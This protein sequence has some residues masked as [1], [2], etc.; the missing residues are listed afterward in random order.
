VLAF[1]LGARLTVTATQYYKFIPTFIL[2]LTTLSL[3]LSF[4]T[5]TVSVLPAMVAPTDS[6]TTFEV[7]STMKQ[8]VKSE[9]YG[10]LTDPKNVERFVKDYFADMPI[11]AR[12]AACES[13]NR[14]FNSNG[15]VLRGEKTPLDR[16]VMQIN[17]YYHAAAAAK[18]GLDLHNIDDNVAYARF[19]YEKYGAK[20]WMSSS[21][22]W[23][24][25]SSNDLAKK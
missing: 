22:C 9:D 8:E 20:P 17:L 6:N 3:L 15:G 1:H 7:E 16:G 14:H 12:I 13:H 19:L 18:M 4:A 2:P 11:M 5:G 25:F 10:P 21:A 24:K 23:S